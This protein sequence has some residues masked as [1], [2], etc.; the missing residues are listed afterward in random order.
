MIQDFKPAAVRD[1]SGKIG[2][3]T[4]V[5]LAAE[6]LARLLLAKLAFEQRQPFL[7]LYRMPPIG[8]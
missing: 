1:G 3:I 6:W 4:D 2:N 7:G 5:E 8:R